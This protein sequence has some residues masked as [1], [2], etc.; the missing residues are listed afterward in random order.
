[1]IWYPIET[2]KM[3]GI[4]DIMIITGHE[5]AGDLLRYLGSGKKYGL[6][7][8][9]R[10]QDKAGGIAH[11]LALA[12]GFVGNDNCAVLL[13]DNVY[14]DNFKNTKESFE[15]RIIEDDLDSQ[16]MTFFKKVKKSSKIWSC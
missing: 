13:G 6:E 14:E 12:E 7:F 9:Y 2:L 10:I 15:K 3:A 16:A 5:H 11:A 1:M 4:T 8:T